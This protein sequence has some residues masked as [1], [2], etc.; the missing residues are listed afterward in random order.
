MNEKEVAVI[1]LGPAG[2]SAAIYL[3]RSGMIPVCFEKDVV[4]GK[5]NYTDKIVNYAGYTE[6]TGHVLA[7]RMEAQLQAFDIVPIF[8]KVQR[9]SL[10]PDQTFRIAYGREEKDFRYVIIAGGLGQKPFAI[11][12]ED[13]FKKKGISR[14][15]ICDGPFYKGKDVAVLGS[16]DDAFEEAL[17]LSSFCH[18]VTVISDTA[19]IQ[20]AEV[21]KEAFRAVPL[22]TVLFPFTITK[23]LGTQSLEHLELKSL[24]DGSIIDLP[25]S[26]LFVYIGSSATSDF[27]QAPGLREENGLLLTD[28]AMMTSV[29]NLY[30]IG[31]CRKTPLRQVATAVGDGALAATMIH[32]DALKKR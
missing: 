19:D 13:T 28:D 16:S 25:V 26:A 29:K 4:G 24:K 32:A 27:I 11:P 20:A 9:V 6:E 1:G 30:A 7:Q 21:V 8:T 18:S 12:G 23:A 31:D 15:A 17:Y 10:N 22:A 5:T 2:V 3:K 14:C